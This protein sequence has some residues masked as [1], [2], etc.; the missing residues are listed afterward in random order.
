M[1]R[2]RNGDED[3]VESCVLAYD[4]SVFTCTMKSAY[5]K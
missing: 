2:G 4:T 5:R 3:E 1:R